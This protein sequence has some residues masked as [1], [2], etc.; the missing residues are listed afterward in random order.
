ML[1]DNP[2]EFERHLLLEENNSAYPRILLNGKYSL[3]LLKENYEKQ[4]TLL[5][6][7]DNEPNC[8][9]VNGGCFL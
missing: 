3:R 6:Y 7:E 4:R 2:A 8:Y 1:K 5:S 9:Q